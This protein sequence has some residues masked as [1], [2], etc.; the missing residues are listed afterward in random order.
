MTA[1]KSRLKDHALQRD[2]KIDIMFT[3]VCMLAKDKKPAEYKKV[4]EE[5][6]NGEYK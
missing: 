4:K 3:L 6:N 5:W 2:E 1:F